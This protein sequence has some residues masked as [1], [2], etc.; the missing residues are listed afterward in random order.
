[1]S[2]ISS[3]DSVSLPRDE[4]QALRMRRYLMAAGTSLLLCAVLFILSLAEHLPWR[5]TA[6]GTGAVIALIVL[7]YIFFSTGLNLRF[8]DPSLTTEQLGAALLVLAYLVTHAGPARS[9]LMLFYP[10]AMLFG[11]LRLSGRR[12]MA[13]AVLALVAH[14]M[15][16]ALVTVREPQL[17]R[18]AL[19]GEYAVLAIVL[20]WFAAMGGYVN[21]LR[22]RLSDSNRELKH[23]FD[24]IEQLAV[25]D[26]L[27]GAYNRRFLMECLA[28]ERSRAER[29][30]S[31]FAVCLVDV[32]HFKA[33]NDELGHAAGDAVLQG[34]PRLAA[35]G[36]RAIDTFGR[37]GGEEFLIV[38]PGTALNGAS[39]AAERVRRAIE[40]A[41]FPAAGERSVTVTIGVAEHARGEDVTALLARADRALY[42]GKAGGRNRVVT[43]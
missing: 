32:D 30:G 42:G 27:T 38:L 1:M 41:R 35:A 16:L 37:F 9:P 40:G 28:G 6:E 23:A 12:M 21:R 7:F 39:A 14:G 4:S 22:T 33:V 13:L 8:S 36:L 26:A 5:V 2:D 18:A 31:T 10:V 29:L 3:S 20:P 19:L 34:L 17:D 25:R 43:G 24:R 11:V 15:M